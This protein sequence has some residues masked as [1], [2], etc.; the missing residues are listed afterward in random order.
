MDTTCSSYPKLGLASP[1]TSCE[2]HC[3]GLKSPVKSNEYAVKV[4]SGTEKSI[5]NLNDRHCCPSSLRRK[6]CFGHHQDLVKTRTMHLK[7][8]KMWLHN[9]LH[10]VCLVWSA[11][12][13]PT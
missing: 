2:E 8:L 6:V 9:V 12:R 5:D 7:L 3:Q 13:V 11:C 1:N 4:I 10:V